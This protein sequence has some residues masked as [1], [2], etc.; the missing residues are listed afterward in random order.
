MFNSYRNSEAATDLII[1]LVEVHGL[2]SPLNLSID[3]KKHTKIILFVLI[4]KM[5]FQL[6]TLYSPGLGT[7]FI[8][9][10]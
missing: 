5:L 1:Y 7:S 2:P 8:I 10:K 4:K 3:T 9:L 6:F